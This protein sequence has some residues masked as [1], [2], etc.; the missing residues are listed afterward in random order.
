MSLSD[1]A[2][3]RSPAS[4]IYDTF[5]A[6]SRSTILVQAVRP[7]TCLNN[8]LRGRQVANLHAEGSLQKQTLDYSRSAHE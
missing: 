6:T 3:R 8:A 1:I 7:K 5:L 2:I 4:I